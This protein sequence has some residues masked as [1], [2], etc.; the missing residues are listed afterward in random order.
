MEEVELTAGIDGVRDR[1]GAILP[2]VV[3]G[4][5]D[6]YSSLLVTAFDELSRSN[7]VV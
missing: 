5:G 1:M 4:L 3:I 7:T 2:V 6:E